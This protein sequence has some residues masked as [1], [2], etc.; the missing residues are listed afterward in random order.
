MYCQENTKEGSFYHLKAELSHS[1]RTRYKDY[2]GTG[3][4]HYCKGHPWQDKGSVDLS[5]VIQPGVRC[6]TRSVSLGNVNLCSH[7]GEQN[8]VS[9]KK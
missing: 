6:P 1:Q 8:G 3:S 7:Y 5:Q 9:L 4:F 2:S